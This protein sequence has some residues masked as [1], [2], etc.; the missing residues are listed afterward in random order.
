MKKYAFVLIGLLG[1]SLMACDDQNVSPDSLENSFVDF[2]AAGG[3]G[4][5]ENGERPRPPKLTEI[6]ITA[7]TSTITDYIATNYVG[8]TIEKAGTDTLSNTIV[9]IKS[10][11]DK[12]GLKFDATGAFV[13]EL[14]RPERPQKGGERG[15]RPQLT[16]VAIADLPTA[17][18]TYITTNYADATIE[19]SGTDPEGNYLILVSIGDKK[20]GVKFNADGSFAEELPPPPKGKKG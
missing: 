7:L 1:V 10:E 15:K 6:E 16:E 19:K 17:T 20:V 18:T 13:E 3:G 11:T 9:G 4:Q 2:A 12:K 14:Q 8:Y 5:G